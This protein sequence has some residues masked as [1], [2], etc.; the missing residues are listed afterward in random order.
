MARFRINFRTI[1]KLKFVVNIAQNIREGTLRKLNFATNYKNVKGQL[2]FNVL[3]K[4]GEDFS[5]F[6]SIKHKFKT[7]KN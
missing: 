3:F 1:G 7:G 6:L 5:D 4:R 2:H